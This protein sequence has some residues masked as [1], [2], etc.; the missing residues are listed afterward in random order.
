MTTAQIFFSFIAAALVLAG[1][2]ILIRKGLAMIIP[3]MALIFS[4]GY[5]Q[6]L[7]SGSNPYYVGF[8]WIL[9][10][11]IMLFLHLMLEGKSPIPQPGDA[12]DELSPSK[13]SALHTF[14]L[15]EIRWK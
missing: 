8:R 1:G 4:G 13:K 15:R 9:L 14:L 5:I 10:L 3:I 11:V 7:I 12:D 2:W 6:Q